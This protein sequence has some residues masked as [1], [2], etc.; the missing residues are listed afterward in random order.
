MAELIIKD[1]P[2]G[3]DAPKPTEPTEFGGFAS[4]EELLAHVKDLEA[5]VSTSADK[6][7]EPDKKEP[8]KK[9]PDKQEPF[10]IAGK[11]MSTFANEWKE[12]GE[13]SPESYTALEAQ[14][15]PKALVDAYIQGQKAA[16]NQRQALEDDVVKD[17]KAIAGGDAGFTALATWMQGNLSAE[18]IQEYNALIEMGNPKVAR[19]AVAEMVAKMQSVEG[20]APTLVRGGRPGASAAPGFRSMAE[21]TA[22]MR[23]PRY[24][25][26]PA[27]RKDVE[28]RVTRSNLF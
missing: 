9:E 20:K 23:D 26:D 3:P 25:T 4:M 27:Y 19:L 11:D 28:D 15:F 18:E 17:I 14:G 2:T 13:L 22:A 5:K 6:K 21:I 24:S 12:R 7:Q 8:D 10:V 1:E 16:Q